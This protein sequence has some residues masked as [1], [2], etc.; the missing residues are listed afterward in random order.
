MTEDLR[1]AAVQLEPVVGD[2]EANLDR[3][4]RL[5][6]R[7]ADAGAEVIVLPEF[8]TTGMAF[9]AQVGGGALPADG[10]ATEM[11]A[12][13]ASAKRVMVGGSFLC[14]GPDGDVRNAFLLAGPDGLIGRHDK[15]LPTMWENYFY[16]GGDDPGVIE[17]P[18]ASGSASPSAGS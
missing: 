6:R 14:R 18:G 1:V 4:E 11:L 17:A 3:A 16:A 8:F 5:A 12:R 10:A 13:V 2:V 7:A 9:L 15:D